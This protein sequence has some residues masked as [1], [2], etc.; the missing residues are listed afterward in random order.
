MPRDDDPLLLLQ[1]GRDEGAS[2]FP[3]R[4]RRAD[5]AGRVVRARDFREDAP[6][7]RLQVPDRGRRRARPEEA[8]TE[9]RLA[10][11]PDAPG[12]RAR[13]LRP[14]VAVPG[15]RPEGAGRPALGT[16]REG[17]GPVDRVQDTPAQRRPVPGA[18]GVE[19]QEEDAV[20][21]G[22][23]GP[24]GPGG[25]VV[26]V[27]PAPEGGPVRR[28]GRLLPARVLPPAFRDVREVEHGVRGEPRPRVAVPGPAYPDGL[29][30]RVR[31]GVHGVPREARRRARPQRPVL[32]AAQRE[33][34]ALPPDALAERRA[35]VAEGGRP[36]VPVPPPPLHVLV[37]LPQAAL[38]PVN[39]RAD[40]RPEGV[41]LL[42]A[43]LARY[44]IRG[45]VRGGTG[46]PGKAE[47][48]SAT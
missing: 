25:R 39:G 31:P 16:L 1:H 14:G 13:R 6:E 32:A 23:A 9:G 2:R 48:D 46:V 4:P 30:E 38:R 29:R 5:G 45:P 27:R 8:V 3:A 18:R 28:R 24:G 19:A 40:A 43:E 15:R 42:R 36:R 11:E 47:L 35:P 34:R 7:A 21:P 33:G 22:R 12:R 26:P 10:P 41:L 20:R 44:R 17:A 37:Q